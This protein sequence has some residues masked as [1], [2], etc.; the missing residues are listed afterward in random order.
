[1]RLGYAAIAEVQPGG[2]FF[3]AAHT[4]ARYRTAFHEPMIARLV[5]FRHLDRARRSYLH[6]PGARQV[7]AGAGGVH[8]A[9]GRGGLRG[10]A[11]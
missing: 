4:M 11:R 9:A 10:S 7:E 1:M 8:A 6:G 3:A 5:E 2:H